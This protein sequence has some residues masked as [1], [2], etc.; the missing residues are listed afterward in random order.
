MPMYQGELD[1]LCG[2]YAIVNALE[3]CGETCSA[4]TFEIACSAIAKNRWPSVLWEG[5]TFEDI[6]KMVKKCLPEGCP[7][8][9]SYPFKDNVP[10]SNND[11]WSQFDL[12]F[13]DDSV[14]CAIVGLTKP[15]LHW[16]VASK[17]GGRIW[18][19]DS[20]AGKPYERKNRTSLHAGSRRKKTSQWLLDKQELIVFSLTNV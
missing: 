19:T 14:L 15:S 18:F 11:Y 5:T 13:E 4:E 6:Q 3:E 16:I 8:N 7:I 9:V 12:I 10:A 2:M 1:G 17:D 20:T